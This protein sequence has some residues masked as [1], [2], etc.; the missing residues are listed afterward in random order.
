MKPV[1]LGLMVAGGAGS[2]VEYVAHEIFGFGVVQSAPMR[3]GA[4]I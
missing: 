4:D 2:F 1:L 3:W